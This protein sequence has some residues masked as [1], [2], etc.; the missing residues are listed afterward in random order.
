MIEF[1][2][3][4]TGI[5]V[6]ITCSIAGVFLVLRKMSM[7]AD[8]ISHTVL[9]GIV[10]SFLVTQAL[11]GVSMFIGAA[12]AGLL[13]AFLVQ[14]LRSNG[15][16]ED[17]AI[18]I[19]FTTLFAISVLL[20]TIFAGDVH[21]DVEHVLMGEIA[22]VPWD[23]LTLFGFEMPKAI[24]MLGIALILNV[25]LLIVFFK[26]FKL[27][28]FDPVYAASIGIPI[29]FM[30]YLFMMMISL[31]TVS[32]FDSVGAILVIAMLIGPAATSYLISRSLKQMFGFAISFGVMAAIGGYY[33]A[34][35]LDTS[36]AG[37]M[38][39]MVGF[40]FIFVFIGQ[41]VNKKRVKNH[42]QS[43]V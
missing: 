11:T 29:V 35:W 1:W 17:A 25:L 28:T 21:L 27:S 31:T 5:L 8:A 13:T 15:I 3:I 12:L 32:A 14:Y 30:H 20:I 10:I 26:E 39:V 41:L 6:G 34:K 18:G 43:N 33:V 22:F 37:M 16:Q 19:I 38:A 40:L 23:K 42:L 9:F 24:W 7:I 36:I 2:V 4:L